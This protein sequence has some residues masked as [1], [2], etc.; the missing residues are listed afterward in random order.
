MYFTTARKIKIAVSKRRK[1]I[2][3]KYKN[4]INIDDGT[5]LANRDMVYLFDNV[6]PQIRFI[7]KFI[8]IYHI[9]RTYNTNNSRPNK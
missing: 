4:I 8:I 5:I 3:D 7:L 9:N 2:K 1:S 6:L